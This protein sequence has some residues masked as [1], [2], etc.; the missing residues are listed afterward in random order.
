MQNLVYKWVDFSKFSQI[1]AKIGSNLGKIERFWLKFKKIWEK[2]GD[3]VKNLA[4]SWADW[5]KNGSLFLEN[6]YLYGSTIKFRGGTSLSKPNL[7]YPPGI[8]IHCPNLLP[9]IGP[10][11]ILISLQLS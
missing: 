4:H 5:Y 10:Y 8:K 7:S 6:W 11:L 1:L 3:F 9:Q 2:S